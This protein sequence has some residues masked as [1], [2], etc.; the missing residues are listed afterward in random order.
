MFRMRTDRR[1]YRGIGAEALD[2]A[3]RHFA[4][5]GRNIGADP[6]T[7]GFCP[8]DLANLGDTRLTCAGSE[9]PE[10]YGASQRS[11]KAFSIT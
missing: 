8:F 3:D 7:R 10:E 5:S 9:T 6:E 1:D 4:A 2:R 11:T